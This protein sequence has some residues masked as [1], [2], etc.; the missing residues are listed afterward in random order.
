MR[1]NALRNASF[2]VGFALLAACGGGGSTGG[3]GGT[4]PPTPTPVPTATPSSAPVTSTARLTITDPVGPSTFAAKKRPLHLP[5]STKAIAVSANG[6]PVVTIPYTVNGPTCVISSSTVTCTFDVQVPAGNDSIVVQAL[7]AGGKVLATATVQ[8]T[9]SGTTVVPVTLLGVPANAF[10]GPTL[11]MAPAGGPTSVPLT[12]TAYD[13]DG[14]TIAGTYATPV[15]LTDDDKSGHTSISPNPVVSSTTAVSLNSDGKAANARIL[16]SFNGPGSG[17]ALFATSIAAH[18]YTVPSG[19]QTASNAGTGTIVMGGDGAMWFGEQTGV[20]RATPTGT[21]TEYPMVQ[22]QQMV[23][24]PDGAVWF[25]TYF[26]QS[27]GK[28]GELC[29]VRR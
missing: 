17:G 7:N 19:A 27:T 21:I 5:A 22:P 1:L 16:T 23:R 4:I 8:Q 15:T 3:G 28:S 13:A 24:G 12:V 25:T 6:A 14:N 20:G 26:D 10:V 29:R 11:S 18:E 9:I 2:L